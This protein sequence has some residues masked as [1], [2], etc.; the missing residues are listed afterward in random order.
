[1]LIQ[2]EHNLRTADALPGNDPLLRIA[3]LLHDVGKPRVKQGERFIG[4]EREGAKIAKD[5]LTRLRFSRRDAERVV[6][7]I[8][9]HMFQYFRLVRRCCAEVYQTCWSRTLG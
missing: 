5:V 4:H 2:Y 1:M 9:H 7:L 8:K 6:H 3:G